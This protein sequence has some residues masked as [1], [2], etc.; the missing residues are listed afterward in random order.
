MRSGTIWWG[1][2]LFIT[3]MGSSRWGVPA[4]SLSHDLTQRIPTYEVVTELDPDEITHAGYELREGV[5]CVYVE[6]AREDPAYQER[7][8][9][10]VESA[11]D[12]R[13][14]GKGGGAHH[15]MTS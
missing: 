9:V 11:F 3:G 1:M 14:A 12:L 5:P 15:Q 4:D 7:Y 10:S 8:W 6:V 2:A 13:G